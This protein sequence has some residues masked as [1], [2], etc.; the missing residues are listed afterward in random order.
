MMILDRFEGD[1]AVIEIDGELTD[2]ER[3]LVDT[4]VKEGDVLVVK[5]GIYYKDHEA[6][7]KRKQYISHKFKDMWED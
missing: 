6:T 4:S 3:Y 2:V 5:E 1:Y 7:E